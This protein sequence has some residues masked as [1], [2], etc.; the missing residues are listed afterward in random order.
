MDYKIHQGDF[1]SNY[2]QNNNIVEK[3]L[4][5]NCYENINEE[6]LIIF[7]NKLDSLINK[8]FLIVGDYDCDG[9]CSTAII[10][11]LLDH[12]NVDNNFY[13]PSR[14][15]DGY[16]LNENI[17]RSAK[18]NN[19]EVI[20]ALD[21]G[22]TCINEANLCKDLNIKLLIIDHHEYNNIPYCEAFLHSNLLS[23]PFNK[24]SAG[25]LCA[26]L[27]NKY[28]DD[29]L[30]YVYGGLA[31]LG[32]MVGVLNYNRYLIKRMFNILNKGKIHQINLLNGSNHYDYH[33][34]HFN[35]I[36]K[37][38]AV[39]RLN[40]NVNVL[41]KYL[42]GDFDYCKGTIKKINSINLERKSL[43]DKYIKDFE[44]NIVNQKNILV[45]IYDDLLEGLC[46]LIAN[47]LMINKGQSVL[48]LTKK[49]NL[50]KGSC[51]SDKNT[52][53]YDYFNNIKDLFVDFGGHENACGLT[54]KDENLDELL[55]YIND[56][57][58]ESKPVYKDIYE[59]DIKDIDYE[60]CLKIE[61][62]FPF[63]VDLKEPLFLIKDIE[64]QNKIIVGNK[65]PKY[66]I[67]NIL[68]AICFKNEI[69]EK[70]TNNFVG[71]INK[72]NYYK[73]H[74]SFYIEDFI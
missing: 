41:V 16:G 30:N 59:M 52:N 40:Y 35:V 6:A 51:R 57:P 60:F 73:N 29:D 63:G 17:I 31:I 45:I 22:A 20:L 26:L 49:D 14:N 9:I 56:Y 58:L 11:R 28:Y 18:K 69:F 13:I 61:D 32:D 47:R 68:S 7:K 48:I 38:N 71:R 27:A 43:S 50:L 67:N 24:L 3:D 46:G 42:L 65:Y 23:E 37:I 10:K 1:F 15:I 36:P 34:I 70:E 5:I 53:I 12:L 4:D 66:H 44:N 55:K 33:S 54:L 74:I 39:S 2:Y 62:L 64:Y 19:Y 25:G 72:D 21:N 8:K